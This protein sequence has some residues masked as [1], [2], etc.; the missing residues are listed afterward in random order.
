MS[1]VSVVAIVLACACGSSSP[2]APDAAVGDGDPDGAIDPTGDG[3][4]PSPRMVE[5]TLTNRPTNA[6]MYSFFVAYQ[7]GSAPW[8]VAPAPTGDTYT[9]PV[10]AP[11]YGV[12]YGCI[13][14]VIGQTTTQLRTV[15]A[16]HFAVGER[17]EL[18]LEVPARCT[19]HQ[20][21]TVQLAG[22]VTN[23][24]F[25]GVLVVQYGT[26]TAF[27]N[28]NGAFAMQVPPGTRD[29]IVAHAVSE[30]NSEF[31][32]DETV[33]L[34]DVVISGPT[35]RTINFSA[36]EPTAYH[37][38]IVNIPNPNARVIAT[39]TLYTA[40]G[41]TLGLVRES[42]DWESDSL[43]AV[44][45]RASDVYDQSI[46]VT[47]FGQGVTVTNATSTPATQTFV[48]PAP[49]GAISSGF[50]TKS[51]DPMILTTWPAYAGSVGYAWNATQQLGSQQCGTN[52]ACTIVWSAYL[53]PGVTGSMPGYQMPDLAGLAGW[54]QAFALVGGAQVVGSVTA[55]TSSAGAGDFPP[56]TP[57]QGTERQFVRTDYAVTP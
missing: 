46:A 34:R 43:A 20:P 42:S 11:S 31:Y 49:L 48:A 33:V 10:S 19:D 30:G 51:P 57:A 4:T 52:A 38:V 6:A 22:T 9:F 14:N 18:T 32:V 3:G 55:Q 16:A 40:N 56:G 8:Q 15:T 28:Q 12:A 1:R 13:G 24:P 36:A 5:L 35:T 54:K 29:L 44:Q 2:S 37:D 23:R 41:T 17:T 26:R 47:T 45:A 53:S 39:T 21:M 27:V 25:S 7:D 50:A